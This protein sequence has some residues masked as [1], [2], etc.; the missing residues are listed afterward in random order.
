MFRLKNTIRNKCVPGELLSERAAPFITGSI[1][2]Q[3]LLSSAH[4]I[5]LVITGEVA[6][7]EPLFEVGSSTNQGK[8]YSINNPLRT[9]QAA[10]AL[11][12][13][14]PF[15]CNKTILLNSNYCS[16]KEN[17]YLN[18]KNTFISKMNAYKPIL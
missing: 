6:S 15:E 14:R 9:K 18:L 4:S 2:L 12:K 8:F 11:L 16:L 17:I 10:R 1:I 13:A 5:Y 3:K 7:Q